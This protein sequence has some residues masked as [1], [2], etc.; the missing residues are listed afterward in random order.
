MAPEFLNCSINSA[1][2]TDLIQGDIWSL[3]MLFFAIINPNLAS[4][5]MVEANCDPLFLDQPDNYIKNMMQQKIKPK[6]SP[7]YVKQRATNWSIINYLFHICTRF[8]PCERPSANVILQLLQQKDPF[9][10]ALEVSQ[11]SALTDKKHTFF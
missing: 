1:T 6:M 11:A 10:T 4:P 3:G 2:T 8:N 7:K 5:F 9:L